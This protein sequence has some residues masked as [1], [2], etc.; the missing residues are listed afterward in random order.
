VS[1]AQFARLLGFGR[2]DA[3]R[4]QIH[5]ALKLDARRIKFMYPRSKQGNFG[6]TMNMLPFHA[7][8]NRLFRRTV[9]PREGDGTKIL[10]YNKNILAA[11][12]PNAN[13]FEFSISDFIWEEIKAISENPLKS[14]GNAPYLM[15]MIE[16]V[17]ART[18]YCEKEH[19]PLRIKNDLK[20]SV[21]DRRAAAGQPVS[22]PPRAARRSGKQGDKPPSPIQK[23]FSFLI[24][25]CK[26]QHTIEVKAQH[27]R[28]ARRKDTKSV[29][30]IHSQLNL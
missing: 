4:A 16:R 15:H 11:M 6:E 19:L 1:Y 26:S 28:R 8:I 7:Y 18:F 5:T 2:K 12:A 23:N 25:V 17:T 29:K 10:T 14:C 9:T 22:S 13:R 30:E 27:E 3:N 21:E 20:A 24:G